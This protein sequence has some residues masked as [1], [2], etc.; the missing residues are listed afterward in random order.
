MRFWFWQAA[1]GSL[2]AEQVKERQEYLRQQR[3]K[4]L[5]MKKRER[6]KQLHNASKDLHQR[7]T[8]ARVAHKAISRGG[9]VSTEAKS[10]NVDDE[11]KLAMRKAIAERLKAEVIGSKWDS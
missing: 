6:E 10:T 1:M 9:D 5:E 3:D 2:T 8:S 7:P 4:L 11:K